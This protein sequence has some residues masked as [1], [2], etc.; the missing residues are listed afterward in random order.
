MNNA[1]DA[2]IPAAYTADDL[3]DTAINKQQCK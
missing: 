1:G 2:N 3:R